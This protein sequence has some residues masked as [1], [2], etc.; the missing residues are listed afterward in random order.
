MKPIL[1][2]NCLKHYNM[3]KSVYLSGKSIKNQDILDTFI[4]IDNA[5][6]NTEFTS[7]EEDI[8]YLVIGGDSFSTVSEL[9]GMHR[10]AVADIFASVCRK[11]SLTLGNEYI[12]R[13]EE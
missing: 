5:I 2:E 3:W 1:V 11:L 8:L 4:D 13:L 12:T 7:I 6:S 10:L 9:L